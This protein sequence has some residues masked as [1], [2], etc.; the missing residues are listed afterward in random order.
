MTRTTPRVQD[1]LSGAERGDD[2]TVVGP[3]EDRRWDDQGFLARMTADIGPD[4]S[5]VIDANGVVRY[6]GGAVERLLGRVAGD[7]IGTTMWEFVHPDDLVAAAGALN[8]ASR[9]EGYHQPALFR[10]RHASGRWVECEVNGVTVDGP[11]GTWLILA[12]RGMDDRDVVMGRRRRIEQIIQSAS[13]ECSGVDWTQSDRVV[14]RVLGELASVVRA[15]SVELAWAES[16]GELRTRS[17]WSL[18]TGSA[19][20]PGSRMT[21]AHETVGSASCPRFE[22][23]WPLEDTSS[24]LLRFS[25]DLSALPPGPARDAFIRS[26]AHAVVEVPLSVSQPFAVLRL[27]FG[28]TWLEWDDVNVDLVV[29]LA[30][31]LM[32]TLRRC[33][34]EEHLRRQ[35]STDG[36]TGLLNRGEL[37]KLLESFLAD[38]HAT[39]DV[40]VLYGD[41]D[42]FKQVN[43]HYGHG[44]GDRLLCEVA[45]AL[46]ASVRAVD[47]VARFGGDE[48][49]VVCPDLEGREHLEQVI[50]RV[51]RSVASVGEPGR[52]VTMS[53][54]GVLSRPGLGCDEMVR[55]AD[56]RMYRDKRGSDGLV[57]VD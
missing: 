57:P 23:L 9:T 39:G 15:V 38:P 20:A 52:R 21:R 54:G 17:S 10:V 24:S 12:I 33:T 41:L 53:I 18:A 51:R 7:Q 44:A 56:E 43:D 26:G 30:S 37:Y 3:D 25:S 13:L 32:A 42:L 19:F 5:C 48:F 36:L 47:L 14:A 28:E 34:A 22:E 8:E 50:D 31:T 4:V 46:R 27:S 11:D 40:G 1:D 49:V 6:A 55:L 29:V 45:D 2:P 16:G 35:A